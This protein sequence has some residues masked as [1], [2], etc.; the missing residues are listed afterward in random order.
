MLDFYTVLSE[1]GKNGKVEIRP[2][3]TIKGHD[4]MIR[5]GVFY[6][7]WDEEAGLWSTDLER[8][9][10]IIDS[11]LLKYAADYKARTGEEVKVNLMN[12]VRSGVMREFLTMCDDAPNKF[13]PLNQKIIFRDE[14][15]KKTD[16][17]STK[18]DWVL[19]DKPCPYWDKL[20]GTLYSPE[21]RHKLEW[22]IG[23]GFARQNHKI[24]KFGVLYGKPGSGK[25]TVLDI[26]EDMI[27]PYCRKFTA[28]DIGDSNKS[29]A[30]EPF[31]NF[32]IFGIESDGNLSLLD[33]NTTLNSVVSHDTLNINTKYGKLFTGK[34]NAILL[35]RS[36]NPVNITDSKSG[37]LRRLIDIN[38]SGVTLDTLEYNECVDQVRF[39][40]GAIANH[41]RNV[42]LDNPRYY[43]SYVPL[44]MLE[45]TNDF[46][47]FMQTEFDKFSREPG[48]TATDAYRRYINFCESYNVKK[49]LT[50]SKFKEELKSYFKEVK[51]RTVVDGVRVRSYYTG[52]IE[53]K[54]DSEN[55]PAVKNMKEFKGWLQLNQTDSIFDGLFKDCLAQYAT[56]NETPSVKWSGCRTTL[57]DINTKKLHYVKVPENHIVIDF[58]IKG[59]DGQKSFEKNLEAALKWP[60]TYAELSK[61]GKGIHLHYDYNG[62]VSELSRIY[63]E[64][65]EIKIFNGGSSLRRKLTK[66]NDIPV[67]VL[68]NGLPKKEKKV[69]NTE[70]IMTARSLQNT[71]AKIVSRQ[72]D[73]VPSTISGMM[74]IKKLTDEMYASGKTYDIRNL[75]EGIELFALS[76]HNHKDECVDIWKSIHFTSKDLEVPEP[77]PEVYEQKV[78]DLKPIAFFDVEVFSNLFLLVYKE[79]GEGHKPAIMFNPTPEEVRTFVSSYRIIGFNN[80]K[81]DNAILWGRM[82]GYSVKGLF[83]LSQS[84]IVDGKRTWPEA[85][86]ISYTDV[87]D[88]SSKK[89]SLKKFE[90]ELYKK[91]LG[92]HHQELGLKW[93]EPAPKELW[94][95]VAE[96]CVNDV[97][98]TELVFEDR[99]GDFAA[100]EVLVKAVHMLHGDEVKA[101]VNNTTN[102]LTS[103]LI[104]GDNKHPQNEFMYRDLS[105]PVT[106][107]DPSMEEFLW[108]NKP[109]MMEYWSHKDSKLP[110]FPGYSFDASRK[111]KSIYKGYVV[112]EGGFVYAEHGIY[113]EGAESD[114]SASHHPS[115]RENECV[116][117]ARY[118]QVMVDIMA[119]RFAAKHKDVEAAKTLFNGA[120]VDII[121]DPVLAKQLAQ[122][123]KIAINSIYGLTSAS[124]PNTFRD[125]RNVDNIVAKRGR[126]FMIDLKEYVESFGYTVIHIKTDSIKIAKCDDFIRNKVIEFA[127]WYG[128][129]FE[130]E[131]KFEK[132]CLVNNAVYIAKLAD[133]DPEEPGKWTA[134]GTQFQVPYVFKNL[135]T[136]EPIEFIDVCET[137]EVKGSLYIDLNEKL[138]EG[139]H[140]YQFIGRVGLFCPVKP[141]LGGGELFREKD[142]KYYA[143][144][145]TKGYRWIEAETLRHVDNWREWIDFTYYNRLV[146]EAIASIEEYG[147]AEAFRA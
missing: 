7:V 46:Y 63:D 120:F 61:S 42:Y 19:E 3:F 111:D 85:T 118:T 59:D 115:S 41:C 71:I 6:R 142:G 97:I 137:K 130:I 31:K 143:V 110:Y 55:L 89:Q 13:K 24:Q 60:A 36:N 54:F 139:E 91:G 114:D 70:S 87:Y 92:A 16:Y 12:H 136:K 72:Y 32:P 122:G 80:L 74:L 128:Y 53:S 77:E 57:S 47:N 25:G 81:Y 1:R 83:E 140:N 129:N 147:D 141:G 27:R 73:G 134:T 5:G 4:I 40:Y 56:E 17:A 29:F 79:A 64:N 96:Y 88:F 23:A 113:N 121:A 18:T 69:M 125:P 105:K 131:H 62:D 45:A 94:N 104:F 82:L 106:Y 99:K 116:F 52:F 100:R 119:V 38:P 33:K 8:C 11:S 102:Q 37:L 21:N 135:F 30:L 107:L 103:K 117:G 51:E 28:Q 84:I 138:P 65:I 49:P 90:V 15:V 68:R 48:I 20:V 39:E 50:L 144:T 146:D 67:T 112:G 132:L 35:I 124:F 26:I 126:L 58:D 10:D 98:T 14:E 95:K 108:K 66:C 93:D 145:G 75:S 78:D 34:I 43:D 2:S 9:V 44:K 86:D 133:D 22:L 123:L 127:K 76:S 101:T 109:E